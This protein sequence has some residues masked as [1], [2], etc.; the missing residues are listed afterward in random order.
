MEGIYL[1]EATIH[2]GP[3][4]LLEFERSASLLNPW[5]YSPEGIEHYI[6]QQNVYLLFFNNELAGVFTISGVI[7]GLFQSAYLGYNAFI[8]H[9]GKGHMSTGIKLL[10]Q[11]VFENKKLH[12]L[13]ANIQPENYA[14]LRFAERAG[15][16]RE[17]YSKNYLRIN[18]EW[19]DH[20]R[21]AII[22]DNWCSE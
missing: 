11:D 9:N 6:S 20:E 4:L 10:L 19:K 13:E 1:R 3:A 12:R 8:P 16:H 2:D 15:F 7:R 17:G 22:N 21:W 18:G 14:S 5:S